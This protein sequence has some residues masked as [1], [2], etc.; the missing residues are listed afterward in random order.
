ME[1]RALKFVAAACAGELLG[2]SPATLVARVCSDSRLAQAGDLFFAIVG[3]RFDGHDFIA[4][5]AAKGVAAVVANR[6][7]IPAGLP[8]PAIAVDNPRQ[9]LGRLAARYRDDFELPVVAVGGSNGKTTTKELIASVLRQRLRLLWSEASFNN[10][11]GVPQ[12]LL[13]LEKTH[14]AA[15]LE[16]GT[17]HP[18]ELAPLVR[19][20]R[21]RLGVI[22]NIGREHL[23]FFGDL[24]GVA[25]EEGALAELLPAGGMLV[26]NG[27]SEWADALARRSPARVVRVGLGEGNDWRA[28]RLRVSE[29]G[30]E[31]FVDAPRAEYSGEYRTPLIGRLQAVN[32]MLALVIGAELKL[33]RVELEKGLAE[34]RPAKM[35]MQLWNWNGAQVLDDAYNANADSTLAALE[36]LRDLPC[37]GRRAAVLGD[38]AELGAHTESA[39]EEVGRRAAQLGLDRLFAV[40]GMAGVTAGAARA[41]GLAAA[42]EFADAAAAVGAVRDYLRAGDVLLLK[43]SRAAKLERLAEALKV[44]DPARKN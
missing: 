36:T 29:R 37:Q 3:D 10:D 34:S 16:V 27:D 6:A 25:N 5:A 19:M 15:V 11:I 20:V 35:R 12:T 21:P 18:G 40:G 44:P 38:M 9:A 4:E 14:E 39:H 23:E 22:T 26:I 30:V 17:N 31:F 13:K 41:A 32:A 2:G 42:E 8:C 28:S 43:A 1:L 7:R 24:A 33:G